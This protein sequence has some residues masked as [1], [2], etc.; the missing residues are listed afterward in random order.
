M[1]VILIMFYMVLPQWKAFLAIKIFPKQ[2]HNSA[3]LVE[4]F[5][6]MTFKLL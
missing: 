6:H 4:S 3:E 1:I 5:Y 2:F